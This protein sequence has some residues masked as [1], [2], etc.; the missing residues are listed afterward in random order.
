MSSRVPSGTYAIDPAHTN[1]EFAVRHMMISSVK[2]RFGD[3]KG[4]VVI[5]DSGVPTIDVTIATGSVDTRNNDRDAHLRS[6]DFFDVEHHPEMR[7][8]STSAVQ[9]RDGWTVTGDLTV[10]GTTR[11]VT[12]AVTEEG[13]GVDPWGNQKAAFTASGKFNRSDYGLT[14]NAALEAG[15]VLVSDEVK[16]VI[17]AQLVRQSSARAA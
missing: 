11:P 8:V 15:G 14:W 3:V 7:F 6:A 17:D 13:T 16:L 2:G 4:T 1:V 5:P 12:L 10:K 9:S